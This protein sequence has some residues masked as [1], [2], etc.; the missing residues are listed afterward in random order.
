MNPGRGGTAPVAETLSDLSNAHER[1]GI[2]PDRVTDY[3]ALV[4]DSSDNIPGVKGIGDKTARALIESYGDLESILAH[5]QEVKGKRAREGLL[6][7]AAAARLSKEL[8]TIKLDV[9]VDLDLAALRVGTPDTEILTRLYTDLEFSSLL[10]KIDHPATATGEVPQHGIVDDLEMLHGANSRRVLQVLKTA[11]AN[12]E[13]NHDFDAADMFVKEIY[14]DEGPVMRRWRP[15]ARGRATPIMKRL[16]HITVKLA[17][18][19]E[20]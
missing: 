4:G 13:N 11:V 9:P 3:L 2:R 5:A 14:I 18:R 15:R 10:A 7:Q 16:S 6:N 17:P 19:G 20:D 8:V 12:A 1:L